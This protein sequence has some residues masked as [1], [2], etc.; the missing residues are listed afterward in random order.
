MQQLNLAQ[1]SILKFINTQELTSKR[2]SFTGKW[3]KYAIELKEWVDGNPKW[4]QGD[5]SAYI[6]IK[7]HLVIVKWTDKTVTI[8]KSHI[9][10]RT[11][12]YCVD[13]PTTYGDATMRHS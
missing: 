6:T 9:V 3:A 7:S 2:T 13:A 1:A 5:D 10:P 8:T 12:E 11:M 4:N